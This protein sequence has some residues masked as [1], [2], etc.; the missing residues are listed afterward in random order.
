M[1]E[2]AGKVGLY[3]NVVHVGPA[4]ENVLQVPALVQIGSVLRSTIVTLR[5]KVTNVGDNL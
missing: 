1:G 3:L 5:R 4:G 2:T